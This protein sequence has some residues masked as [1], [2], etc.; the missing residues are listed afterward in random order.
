M[1]FRLTLIA[2]TML[3]VSAWAVQDAA[4]ADHAADMEK[5]PRSSIA[6]SPRCS[7]SIA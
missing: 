2:T 5:A 6:T 1:N 7:P 4:T 3:S